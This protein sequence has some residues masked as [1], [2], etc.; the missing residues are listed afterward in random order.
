MSGNFQIFAGDRMRLVVA[1]ADESGDAASLTAASEIRWQLGRGVEGPALIEK[2]L[3]AGVTILDAAAGL[4]E[5]LLSPGDT[6]ALSGEFHH[7]AEIVDP[8]GP[9]TV[10]Y[11]RAVIKPTLIPEVGP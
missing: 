6:A 4:F 11:G 8:D 9:A 10:I 5:V 7:E 3:G 1:V 2:S